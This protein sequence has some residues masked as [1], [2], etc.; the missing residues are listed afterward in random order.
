MFTKTIFLM[1]MCI[2]SFVNC[3]SLP[4]IEVL[5][6]PEVRKNVHQDILDSSN[7]LNEIDSND[8][9]NICTTDTC[10]KESAIL[11]DSLDEHV[12]PC[13]DFYEFACGNYIRKIVLPDDKAVDLS[14]LNVQDK[15]AEQLRLIL[16]EEPL[17][18]ESH[19]FKLAKEFNKICMD[20]AV[21][22]EQGIE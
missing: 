4:N 12:N 8:I 14:F 2:T 1:C 7:Q 13:E 11:L 22:N 6:R 18:N 16:T 10:A 15:V 19:P 21:L 9:P 17:L 20:E 5:T 3:A